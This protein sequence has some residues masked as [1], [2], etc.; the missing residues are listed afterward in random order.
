M[1]NKPLP[2]NERLRSASL[3]SAVFKRQ[4]TILTDSRIDQSVQRRAGRLGFDIRQGQY[5]FF[6]SVHTGSGAQPDSNTMGTGGSF[7]GDKAA[8]A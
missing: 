7:P 8:G 6:H 4:A 1:C 5:I 2:S 3:A